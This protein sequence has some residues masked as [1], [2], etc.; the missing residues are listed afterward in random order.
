MESL[1]LLGFAASG[2]EMR[3]GAEWFAENQTAD[4]LW[5]INN[6]GTEERDTPTV[7]ERRAWLGLR[8]CRLLED[9]E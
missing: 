2:P 4:G 9:L 7:R 5:H 8:I 1:H 6:D 3:R